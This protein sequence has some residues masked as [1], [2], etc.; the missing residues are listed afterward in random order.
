MYVASIAVPARDSWHSAVRFTAGQLQSI[1]WKGLAKMY[2]Q[3]EDEGHQAE[4]N[5]DGHMNRL[6]G[7]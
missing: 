1:S 4:C 6:H 5:A 7:R 2:L 3:E